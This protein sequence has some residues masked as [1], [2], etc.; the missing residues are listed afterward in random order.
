MIQSNPEGTVEDDSA[1]KAQESMPKSRT[2]KRGT[3][4]QIPKMKMETS[5]SPKLGASAKNLLENQSV[6]M[7][8]KSMNGTDSMI[9]NKSVFLRTAKFL[10]KHNA[11]SVGYT[12]YFKAYA[13]PKYKCIYFLQV[14]RKM[15]G[16]RV[17]KS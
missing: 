13:I 9:I 11:F 17:A 10:I 16:K 12:L 4:T 6:L 14:G 3:L 2:S 5:K 7:K 8:E 15:Y 1:S